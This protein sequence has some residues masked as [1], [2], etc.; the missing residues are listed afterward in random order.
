MLRSSV[1]SPARL[2]VRAIS[3]TAT[4][5]VFTPFLCFAALADRVAPVRGPSRL[6]SFLTQLA[7]ALGPTVVKAGQ[8]LSSRP[9]VLPASIRDPLR[10][11]HCRVS[12]TLW[13]KIGP[14]IDD[15]LG[16]RR[17]DFRWISEAPLAAGSVAQVHEGEL[18][19]GERVALKILRPGVRR[20]ISED[21]TLMAAFVA[22][23]ARFPVF[24]GI[25]I[26]ACFEQVRLALEGQTRLDIEQDSLIEIGE[27]VSR[28]EGVGTPRLYA[29]YGSD[30]LMVME[31]V[32]PIVPIDEATKDAATQAVEWSM[33]QGLRALYEMVFVTGL[34]HADLHPGNVLF[35]YPRGLVLVDFGLV[36]RLKPADRK[37]F[38]DLFYG[39]VA[40]DS[41]LVADVILR[42]ATYIPELIQLDD[43]YLEVS[44]LVSK[45]HALVASTFEAT[46]VA[47]D[48]FAVQQKLG[49]IG[50]PSFATVIMSIINFES[51]VKALCP[52]L[53]FQKTAREV[54]I[55][56]QA[57]SFPR[58]P[59]DSS[60]SSLASPR[61]RQHFANPPA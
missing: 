59:W 29:Q 38:R 43:L 44:Q 36:A 39:M 35:R 17:A 28:F 19:S 51:I 27:S 46:L 25:A 54:L 6:G 16:E 23:A 13:S 5:L 10:R 55:P 7:E 3:A 9:D 49:I 26:R 14:S 2:A 24:R 34:V 20:R 22:V 41:D 4:V 61:F 31:R 58:R 60:I 12:P 1:T 11:L 48:L 8:L 32:D 42:Q 57:K 30:R 21:L 52:G 40:P 33:A 45:H 15:E 56:I 37:D 18:L 47:W 53:D 50:S